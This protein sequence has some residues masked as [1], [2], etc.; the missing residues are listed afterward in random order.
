MPPF[1]A[2]KPDYGIDAPG[3]IRNLLLIGL[4]LCVAW[5]V[6]RF[7]GVTYIRLD[8]PWTLIMGA[9]CMLEGLAMLAYSKFGKFRHRDRML[10]KV[11]WRGDE[12]VLDVGTGRGLLLIGAAKRLTTGKAVGIDIWSKDDL[13]AN[14]MAAT[15]SNA[16]IEGVADRVELKTESATKMNFDGNTF[17]VVLS[18]LCIHNI[19]DELGRKVACLEI[20]RVLKAGG[21]ALIS[22]FKNTQ[23]YASALRDAGL[24]VH[25]NGPYLLSTFPPL[26]V[27]TARKPS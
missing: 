8:R 27:I 25:S 13:S 23:H 5:Y 20:A 24:E 1:M 18:N 6:W 9:I 3:V 11:Q 19:P 22:D 15:Q 26:R 10:A 14:S 2:K 16:E 12:R 7:T 4:A 17:D 21:V